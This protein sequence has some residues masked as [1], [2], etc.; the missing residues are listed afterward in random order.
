MDIPLGKYWLSSDS[1]NFVISKPPVKDK[2][3]ISSYPAA[4]Y[5]ASIEQAFNG[6]FKRRLLESDATTLENLLNELSD[7][8]NELHELFKRNIET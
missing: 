6:L 1:S 7:I 8:K 2:R 3:G 4:T 5:H